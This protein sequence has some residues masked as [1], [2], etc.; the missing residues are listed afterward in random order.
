[1]TASESQGLVHSGATD[2]LCWVPAQTYTMGSDRH[3]P[4]EGPA[5]A[6]TVDGFWMESHEVTNAQFAAFVDATGYLTVAERPLDQPTSL[7]PRRRIYSRAR[8]C[9]SGRE[10]PSISGISASGGPGRQARSGVGR[11][12]LGP[13][14]RGL[15]DHP[16][17]HVAY[18]DAEAYAAWVG[19]ELPTEAE[20]EAAARGGL[21]QKTYTWGDEPEP[22]GRRLAN[23][24]HGDFPWR[25]ARGYGQT[26]AVG[27]F[28]ANAYGLQDMAGN[29]WE[30][31]ADWYAARHEAGA[32]LAPCCLPRN[33]RGP[34]VAASYDPAQPQ[35]RV[36]RR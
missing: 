14:L 11:R 35:F 31:T 25:P 3:Y 17:V 36:P 30:W 27:G 24:W 1:M 20:W 26:A 12:D 8:W 4:E 32:E 10:V 21:D 18:E 9:S 22:R 19:S 29:V 23:Y 13:R 34:E 16:V 33:P 2:G 15:A 7:A 28:P 6:V 5:H